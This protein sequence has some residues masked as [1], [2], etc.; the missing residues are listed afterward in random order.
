MPTGH[1]PSGIPLNHLREGGFKTRQ[2]SAPRSDSARMRSSGSSARMV[3]IAAWRSWLNLGCVFPRGYPFAPGT[4]GQRI[5]QRRM[6]RG[7]T[8][9]TVAERLGCWYQSVASWERDEA[10]PLAA[11]WPAVEAVLGPGLVPQQDGLPGRARARPAPARAHPGAAGGSGGTRCP[12]DPEHRRRKPR[13]EPSDSLQAERRPGGHRL[14]RRR[15]GPRGPAHERAL[16]TRAPPGAGRGARLPVGRAPRPVR[17]SRHAGA[18]RAAR[19]RRRDPPAAGCKTDT[20]WCGR[21]LS[22]AHLPPCLTQR[23]LNRRLRRRIR[24]PGSWRPDPWRALPCQDF[25]RH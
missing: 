8:Q 20:S 23:L 12:D 5:R 3:G 14:M 18:A 24:C 1:V 15:R 17:Q 13:T 22:P 9:R 16:R 2:F 21:S 25:P 7:L 10:A 11:R 4:L 6:D 19:R